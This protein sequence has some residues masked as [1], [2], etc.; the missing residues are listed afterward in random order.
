MK[1]KSAENTQ[2]ASQTTRT[3]QQTNWKRAKKPTVPHTVIRSHI[4]LTANCAINWDRNTGKCK[5]IGTLRDSAYIFWECLGVYA[6]N[7]N[8]NT[9]NKKKMKKR[10]REMEWETD[11]VYHSV[12]LSMGYC[13]M[14]VLNMCELLCRVSGKKA[15]KDRKK[16]VELKREWR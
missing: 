10:Q 1:E 4:R 9:N 16:R 7:K 5:T 8:Y 3:T 15:K 2:W 14:C 11:F 13:W 12:V 6:W